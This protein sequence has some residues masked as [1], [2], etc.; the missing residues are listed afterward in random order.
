MKIEV[1]PMD[2]GR[3]WMAHAIGWRGRNN[4]DF[5]WGDSPEEAVADFLANSKRLIFTIDEKT[6]VEHRDLPVSP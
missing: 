6:L 2:S 3:R 4:R 5:G 1:K